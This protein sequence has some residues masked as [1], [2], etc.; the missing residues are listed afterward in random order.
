MPAKEKQQE[1]SKRYY[2][3]NKETISQARC[4]SLQDCQCGGTYVKHV[5]ARHEKTI[6]HRYFVE[7]GHQIREMLAEKYKITSK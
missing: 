6:R 5:K 1:Y 4:E 3:K 7:H 2:E